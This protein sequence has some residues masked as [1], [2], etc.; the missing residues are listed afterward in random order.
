MW[1]ARKVV[2]GMN[3]WMGRDTRAMWIKKLA[4]RRY[5]ADPKAM[6]ARRK[7]TRVQ[8]KAELPKGETAASHED[9]DKP[10]SSGSQEDKSREDVKKEDS[11]SEADYAPRKCGLPKK[12]AGYVDP[13]NFS[14]P[15]TKKKVEKGKENAAQASHKDEAQARSSGSQEEKGREDAKKNYAVPKAKKKDETG[16]ER[17][18]Q[19]AHEDKDKARSSGSQEE[20]GQE[21]AKK[22]AKKQDE[23]RKEKT[24]QASHEDKDTAR[25]SGS[26]EEKGQGDAKKNAEKQ[27]EK[28]KEKTVQA[29]HEDKDIARSSGSQ[30]EK[31][32]GDAKNNDDLHTAKLKPGKGKE[33]Q[34]LVQVKIEEEEQEQLAQV[35]KGETGKDAKQSD[36]PGNVQ[37]ETLQKQDEAV[38]KRSAGAIFISSFRRA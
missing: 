26:Q 14:Q 8:K 2:N 32:Q 7:Q 36:Q 15:Q 9:K 33:I 28:R 21:D 19:A 13:K 10:T 16:N 23:K 12:P 27:D 4:R 34:K 31:G 29:S 38:I 18:V 1:A 30:E 17:T 11:D 3:L 35:K 20:K 5:V 6:P 24:V 25:S 22:N 37:K